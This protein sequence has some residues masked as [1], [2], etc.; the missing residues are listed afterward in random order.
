MDNI[1]IDKY[2]SI[3]I[4]IIVISLLIYRRDI[5]LKYYS[6]VYTMILFNTMYSIPNRCDFI[7]DIYVKNKFYNMKY[8]DY[9]SKNRYCLIDQ[10]D[11]L[12]YLEKDELIKYN[13][14]IIT[15][16]YKKCNLT[17]KPSCILDPIVFDNK[18]TVGQSTGGTS[19]KSTFIWMNKYEGYMYIYTFITSFKKNGYSYGDKVMV[20]YPS[21]SY[22]T[23]EYEKTNNFLLL[24]NFYFLSFNKIDRE[25]TIEFVNSINNNCPDFI[26]IFPFVLL[27]LCINIKKYNIKLTHYPKN[28]NLSGEFLLN[29]SL[30]FCKQVF[31]NSNIEN[32]YGAV[33]FGEIAHQVKGNKNEFEVFSEF[34]YLENFEDKIVV[35]SF[36]NRTFPIVRYIMEDIG[37]IV[38]KDGKQYIVD[39]IGKNTN[40]IINVYAVIQI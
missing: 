17:C 32:T 38:N 34:C 40:Q 16:P 39:L 29:C 33:E 9:Y 18:C 6:V 11:K 22:F 24:I 25:K 20:F 27:Q 31:I 8:K 15:Y 13:D 35:S 28:I 30:H 37:K 3:M 14:D 12:P 4:I 26:V 36:I 23:N 19:G 2:K 5:V 10:Y 21:H 1:I 7:D